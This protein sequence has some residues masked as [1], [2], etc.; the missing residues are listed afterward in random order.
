MGQIIGF[1]MG[2]TNAENFCLGPGSAH[3]STA[4]PSQPPQSIKQVAK[5]WGF[6][7]HVGKNRKNL[8]FPFKSIKTRV[9]VSPL[10]NGRLT[11][12][13]NTSH[14]L[15][16]LHAITR[17]QAHMHDFENILAAVVQ[18]VMRAG[19]IPLWY[20]QWWWWGCNGSGDMQD[21]ASPARLTRTAQ[22][23][24]AWACARH[25]IPWQIAPRLNTG[26]GGGIS[27]E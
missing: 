1:I 26:M 18:S 25:Y 21:L 19:W 3:E 22:P 14:S 15:V 4:E 6:I 24:T 12:K 10:K 27:N 23:L 13:L 17:T 7:L 5:K 16:I 2:F 11:G 8:F 9:F 20:W